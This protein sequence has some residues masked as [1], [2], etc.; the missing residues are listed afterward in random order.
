[1][2]EEL[3]NIKAIETPDIEDS[4]EP[5]NVEVMEPTEEGVQEM[6]QEVQ[7][8]A[9]EFYGNLAEDM[10]ERVLSRIAMDLISD[11]KKDKESRSD[12]E[13]SYTSGLDLLGFKYNNEVARSKERVP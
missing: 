6:M 13:K 9:E 12:W 5:V 8:M 10:D 11:Y 3:D 1:M 7:E 2:A 4:N